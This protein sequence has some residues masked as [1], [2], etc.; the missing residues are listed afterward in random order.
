MKKW[1][2]SIYLFLAFSL[3]G[4]AVDEHSVFTAVLKEHVEEGKVNYPSL[5]PD[6]RLSRYL[7]QLTI[8]SPEAL[9]SEK[10]RLA[11]WINVYNAY[12]LKLICDHYPVKSINELHT[13]GLIVGSV[14]KKTAWD[15]KIVFV[16]N[17]TLSLGDV[18]H[19]ILRPVFKDPRIH[20]AIVCAA[21]SCP[22]LRA[23]AYEP[24]RIDEQLN[25]QGRLFLS[26]RQKNSFDGER[27]QA[28]LSPIFS[29]FKEDFGTR[30]ARVLI[31]LSAFVDSS[32]KTA[33]QQA[34]DKWRIRYSDYD[35][36][37][38]EP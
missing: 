38:N 24:A 16:K 12:T 8:T 14:I 10:A 28:T 6:A 23:E 18:E 11:F 29:W 35:W 3:N 20:F 25:D 21:K 26:D 1:F 32:T 17:Q 2:L 27:Q 30:P 13:G 37:L 19:K 5:C 9:S 15:R 7:E 22:P 4:W 31:F 36:S 33:I 34:P